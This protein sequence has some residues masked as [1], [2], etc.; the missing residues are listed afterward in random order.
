MG[1][2]TSSNIWNLLIW[3]CHPWCWMS[4]NVRRYMQMT[5]SIKTHWEWWNLQL[6]FNRHNGRINLIVQQTVTTFVRINI[7]QLRPIHQNSLETQWWN[8]PLIPC[9]ATFFIK[10]QLHSKTKKIP[11]SSRLI[12]IFMI[13]PN[14]TYNVSFPLLKKIEYIM[15]NFAVVIIWTAK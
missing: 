10:N 12:L 6:N 4:N 15:Y 7:Q 9:M 8:D 3:D 14:Y 13:H 11:I 2:Y 1:E 5:L